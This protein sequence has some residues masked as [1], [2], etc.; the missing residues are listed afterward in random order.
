[1]TTYLARR[2]LQ[3][4]VVVLLVTIIVFGLIRLT[5]GGATASVLGGGPAHQQFLA[6]YLTWLGR[7]LRGDLGYSARL[8]QSV[9]SLLATSLPRTLVLDRGGDADRAGDR[10]PGRA[11]PGCAPE[12]SR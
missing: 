8:N 5:P 1:M 10:D 12:L 9:G 4:V 6:Q 3:A 11:D 7:V 2:V